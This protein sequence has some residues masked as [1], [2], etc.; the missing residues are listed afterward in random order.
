MTL[1]GIE[2][3]ARQKPASVLIIDTGT[4]AAAHADVLVEYFGVTRFRIADST[5]ANV[6][7]FASALVHTRQIVVVD[8]SGA[9]HEA[10]DLI[11][12]RVDWTAVV[13]RRS[14]TIGTACV[15]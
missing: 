9:Q 14:V 3:L 8:L 6:E 4:Q 15:C 2:T 11:Q 12:V 13:G 1:L 10:G 5:V 7:S